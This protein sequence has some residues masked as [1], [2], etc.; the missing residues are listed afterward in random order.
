ALAA[1]AAVEGADRSPAPLLPPPALA[2]AAALADEAPP[3]LAPAYLDELAG[4]LPAA[5]VA[6]LVAMADDS[7]RGN[8][9]RVGEAWRDD[10]PAAAA[11]AA[12]RLAGVAGSYGLPALRAVAKALETAARAED[13]ATVA[14]LLTGLD[15][16]T[17]DSI[18]ALD[19]WC[20]G[21][22]GP[23]G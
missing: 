22:M 3:L 23:P 9:A 8:A 21:Q 18:R 19:G 2:A 5:D 7:L 11:A 1:A 13:R 15:T 10:D 4:A 14:T 17:E 6:R 20:A 12:H 16:L